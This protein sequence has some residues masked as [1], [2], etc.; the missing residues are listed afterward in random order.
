MKILSRTTYLNLSSNELIQHAL[1]NGEGKLSATGA[2]AVTTG[3]TGR[4]PNDRFIVKDA[5]T[6]DQV[7]WGSVNQPIGQSTFDQLWNKANIYLSKRTVYVSNLQVG[8][9]ENYFLP[10]QV[11]TEFAWHNL[12]VCNLF[13]RPNGDY[14]RGKPVWT[15]LSVP[16]LKTNPHLDKVNSDGAV[17]INISQ[18]CILLLGMEYA[19]EMKKAMFTVMNYLL[20]SCDVLPMHC[21][22]NAGKLGDVALFFGLSG[23]GKTTLSADPT[24]FLIG[25]DEHGWSE[26]G[27]FNFEGGCYAKCIGLSLER[28]PMIWKAIRHGAIMENVVLRS[29]GRPDYNDDRLTQNTR[30]AYPREHIFLRVKANCGG[31]PNAVIFLTCDLY[32]VL[33]PVALLTKEQAVYYFLSG[34]TAVIGNTEVGSTVT[35]TFSTCFGAPFFP[36]PPTVYAELLIKRIE[37]TQCSVYLVNTGWMGGAY[38]EGGSRLSIHT[39]RSI[40]NHI[41]MGKLRNQFTENLK[42]FN[43][44]IPKTIPGVENTNPRHAWK[45]VKSYDFQALKLI[46]QFQSNFLKFQVTETIRKAGPMIE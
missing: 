10:V 36:R 23:T 3:R 34:Y 21:A 1:K 29:D 45:D 26:T 41:L 39:T 40:V 46:K 20:P 35:P 8:A 18:R 2:L 13:I 11:V 25:D 44:A 19:G 16:G 38:G 37:E 9:D 7:H 43:L 22:A 5:T 12:F 28:E 27:V 15:I 32:G 14:A 42:G 24:R 30:A 6:A 17:I 33:P 4:S 31:P